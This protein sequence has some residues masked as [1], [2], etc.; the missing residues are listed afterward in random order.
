MRGLAPL[1]L[2]ALLL[3]STLWLPAPA[4]R[5][6][7]GE[8]ESYLQAAVRL[9]DSLD[10]ERALEYLGRAKA[11]AGSVDDDVQVSL[12]EGI[13]LAELGRTDDSTAAFRAALLL[14]PEARLPLKVSPKVEEA[15][16]LEQARVQ[17]ELAARPQ[18]PPAPPTSPPRAKPPTPP[19]TPPPPLAAQPPAPQVRRNRLS[20]AF[21]GLFFGFYTLEY[22]RVMDGHI[23][24]LAEGLLVNYQPTL[25]PTADGL[26]Q[27]GGLQGGIGA[28]F[29]PL[30]APDGF[31][32][33]PQLDL[34]VGTARTRERG[35][36]TAVNGS[37]L[38][39]AGTAGY[40]ATLLDWVA[41]G[42]GA[43]VA[44][45]LGSGPH[46]GWTGRL[47]LSAGVAF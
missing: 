37:N 29:Y 5:A 26:L 9:Y 30:G 31:Y 39:L 8:F 15:F 36:T 32:L 33:S 21:V 3:A 28:R 38:M 42:V 27:L 17:K 10:Y 1:P 16:Q 24:L 6:A 11:K 43:G 2:V 14:R 19:A 12:Y 23:S 22:E 20:T 45:G 13:V 7:P 44:Y 25:A 35:V 46:R 40:S 47:R 18:A 34:A 41:V 4:A